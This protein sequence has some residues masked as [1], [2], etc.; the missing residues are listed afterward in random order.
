[1][2]P[3][4]RFRAAL[5]A[6]CLCAFALS[7]AATEPE[8][9][10][11]A[12]SA[13]A[14]RLDGLARARIEAG[15]DAPGLPTATRRAATLLL[16]QAYL[17]SR[18]PAP[19]LASLQALPSD[20]PEARMLRAHT[21]ARLGRWEDARDLYRAAGAVPDAPLAARLGEAE[22][23]HALGETAQAIKILEAV[24]GKGSVQPAVHLRLASLYIE[25]GRLDPAR[26][27]LARTIATE[28]ADRLWA[29]YIEARALL[30]EKRSAA[31]EAIFK[32]IL[33]APSHLHE[34][35]FVAATLGLAET[36]MQLRGLEAA[37][38]VLE[39]FIWRNPESAW[40]ELVFRRLDHIYAAQK[41]PPESELLKWTFRAP[42]RRATLAHYYAAR[43]QVRGRKWEKALLS[44]DSFVRVYPRH[45]LIPWIQLLR[46]EVFVELARYPDAVR[47]L[48]AASR[49]ATTDDLRAEIDL[50]TGL[51]LLRQ[52]EYVLA[53]TSL[54]RAAKLSERL[55]RIAI[56]N[57]AIAWL[58]QHNYARFI[59]EYR[60]LADAGASAELRGNLILEEA[61][62][63]ARESDPAASATLERFA[64]QFPRHPRIGEAR[65]AQAEL[66]LL[67]GRPG[68]AAQWLRAAS[69][70]PASPE[71]DDHAAY[72]AI[73]LAAAKTPRDDAQV[74]RLA[75]D[76]LRQRPRSRLLPEVRMKLG[77][78]YFRQPDY[79]N[80]ETQF[81]LLARENPQSPLAEMAL[82]LAGQAAARS[83]N[84]GST[85]R[86]LAH[87][88][89]VASRNGTLKLAAREQQAAI[90]SRLGRSREAI[91]LY[92]LILASKSPPPT[93][94]LRCRALIGK[95][96]T[97]A[98]LGRTEPAQLE[99]AAAVFAELAALPEAGPEWT[100][101]GRYRQAR[102]FEQIKRFD[103]ALALY[104]RVLDENIRA[105][106]PE[107]FWFYKA[108]FAA[109]N[110]LEQQQAWPGA[111]ALYE[112]I[113]TIDGPRAAEA[114]DRAR[115]LR[116]EHFVWD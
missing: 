14:D 58:N 42:P 50:R 102:L 99:A 73:F 89:E 43:M 15:L 96:E 98:T 100:F 34:N 48:E 71:L 57:A 6:A 115:Q 77:E 94:S 87:L 95:G 90:Q 49:A 29:R 22:S 37:D 23:C 55:H 24:A 103:D 39:T 21:F 74:I 4:R 80:A 38:K 62:V 63:R 30:T 65:L 108:G 32:E 113:A 78:V 3:V 19:A 66:A 81:T 116:I 114:R 53:A 91:A 33:E 106:E 85:E 13:L 25:A 111:I 40:I 7:A 61:L 93:L 109:A 92:D 97:L 27:I 54:E 105:A 28:P 36:R 64:G 2:K 8:W 5:P 26:S 47:A 83:I 76:F 107:F 16:A 69:E 9:L 67:D 60:R 41:S 46:A 84:A 86:A 72:L 17:A 56:Y 104:H 70:K 1:M 68:E 10:A 79:A 82:F 11:Q 12:R 112:K 35:L 52:R 44:L 75:T 18:N 59:E 45:R 88:D 101:Q 20:D 31:A 51:V 110:R